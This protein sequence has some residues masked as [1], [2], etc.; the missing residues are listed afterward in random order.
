LIFFA[1]EQ[2]SIEAKSGETVSEAAV[3]AGVLIETPCGGMGT[4]GKCKVKT[5]NGT[6]LACQTKADGDITVFTENKENRSLKIKTS[7]KSFDYPLKPF[8][9]KAFDGE[10]TSVFGGG[11]LLGCED[12]DNAAQLYGA[13]FDIGTTTLV[14][15]LVDIL[16][17]NELAQTSRLNPQ[18]A[19]AQDVLARIRFAS[20][21]D[22]LKTLKNVLLSA[23]DEM[24]DEL[25]KSADVN[26]TR[27]YEAV[28][29][30][31]TAMLH[32][33][34]GVCP[35]PLGQYPYVSQ[36]AGG[37]HVSA[38]ELSISP[39]GVIYLPPIISAFVGPDITSGVLASRLHERAETV[40][41][42]DIGTNGEIVLACNG[43]LAATSTAAGPAF[44]GMNIACGT[45]A[46]NG[47]LEAFQIT[48]D[49]SRAYRVI[50]DIEASGICGSG[51]IDIAG[52][53][54]RTGVIGKNGRFAKGSAGLREID[55]KQAY[56]ITDDVFLTQNDVRQIQLAKGAIL[57]GIEALLGQLGLT[58]KD[59][60]KAEIA[61]SFGY[62]LNER[63]L[64]NIG[65]LPREFEGKT[66]FVG[67]TAKT[68]GEAFLLNAGFREDM[69]RVAGE[70]QKVE[71]ANDEA[72]EKLFVASLG[73][74]S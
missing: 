13:V 7:G 58:A 46:S 19:Y 71:L 52:E 59:V 73:F 17:G 69:K 29:S 45:R 10:K 47:A 49:G 9:T 18:S 34:C 5:E 40:L 67:N 54:V 24:L 68:G 4:C 35:K 63:S 11:D 39:F 37:E 64:I 14:A 30:G 31:N 12:G 42:I 22:G 26:R 20:G 66:S 62:H 61:G 8:I 72:F 21:E 1:N 43:R 51:L 60:D 23:F 53:L 41:F 74:P 38:E 2:I 6:V 16:T 33:A 55:G 3:R 44:E 56:F 70:I 15:A 25:T 57:S 48:D 28:Y 27:I 36:I 65:L 50:G 32:L